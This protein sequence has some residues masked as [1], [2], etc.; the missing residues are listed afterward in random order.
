MPQRPYPF[1]SH[2]ARYL[3]LSLGLALAASPRLAA[4]DEEVRANVVV[5]VDTSTSMREPGMDPERASLLV[6]QLLADI[7]PGEFA[8]VR[9]LDIV[10]D[11]DALP[12]RETGEFKPCQ[13]DPSR[14]CGLVE[15]ASDWHADAR[16]KKLGSLL[17]PRI[18]DAEYKKALIG[19]LDQR[20]GNSMF[21]LAFRAAQGIFD[22]GDA[23]STSWT[24]I[25]LSDG[26]TDNP[27]DLH[28]VLQELLGDGIGVEPL[29]FG[30]GDLSLARQAGLEPRQ[31]SSPREM[32]AAFA[33]AFR[34]IVRAPF[35]I[36]HRLAETPSFEMKPNVDEAWVVVYGDDSLAA[37]HLE[38]PDG[39]VEADDATGRWPGAGAYRVAHLDRPPAGRFTV[40]AD[41][42]G[43]GVAYAVIQRSA[44]APALLAPEKIVSGAT[45]ELVA[46]VRA[47]LDGELVTDSEVLAE[48]RLDARFQGREHVLEVGDDGRFRAPVVFDGSGSVDV[49]LHLESPVVDRTSRATVDVS[50]FFRA[51][52]SGAEADLGSLKAGT[53]ACRD[54][55]IP[56]RREGTVPLVVQGSQ[57]LP[58]GHR[59][60]IR[61]GAEV[62]EPG[63]E[64][65]LSGADDTFELCL[66]TIRR[67][68]DSDGG[69]EP[70][71]TLAVDGSDAADAEVPIAI[72]WQVEALGF[73]ELWG[74]LIL[75]I[76]GFLIVAFLVGGFLWPNRFQNALAVAFVPDAEDL[77]EQSPQPIRQWSG[78]GI[79]FY[80]H[81]RAFLHGDFRL[82]GRAQ[83]A[84]AG[85]YA[86]KHGTRVEVGRG[87]TLFRETLDGDWEAVP[88]PGRRVRPGDIYRL[89]ESGP[90]F[91]I[92]IQGGR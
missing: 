77:D 53:S 46:G 76:L 57:E 92:A 15:P 55:E 14:N 36:D 80:R 61:R 58:G 43:D 47:G 37:A 28:H 24:V 49:E 9:L 72:D 91:R 7:V 33:D 20:I 52:R 32:M 19:H 26:R 16:E 29:V 27:H 41:G 50:G 81:A 22:E 25:W 70:W 74:R 59:L 44:L 67:A 78:V 6:T 56:A 84:L 66:A 4:G 13:E 82:S 87:A 85:L 5:V 18:R 60:F 75:A 68:G 39:R 86:E 3:V 8:V 64:P 62:L 12:S 23:S 31:V 17:R 42:G 88:P 83:G 73:W 11:A 51:M 54:L 34:R 90:F 69:G 89:G 10:Q 71:L 1:V 65:L 48:S 30:G 79:G 2:L 63:G 40:R 38:G 45:T 21:S 35:E